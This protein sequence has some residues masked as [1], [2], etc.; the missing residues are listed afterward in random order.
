MQFMTMQEM[1]SDS[2]ELWMRLKNEGELILTSN[3]K[4]VAL[5][6]GV[7]EKNVEKTLR[8]FRQA[9]AIIAVRELQKSAVRSGLN[10]LT[11]KRIDAEIKAARRRLRR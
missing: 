5:L 9:K 1:R 2:K 8:A 11:P 6:A 4:P 7:T 10:K 3:G